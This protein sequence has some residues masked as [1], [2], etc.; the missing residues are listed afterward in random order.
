M[1]GLSGEAHGGALAGLVGLY[2]NV[3]VLSDAVV[4]FLEASDA[5]VD[6]VETFTGTRFGKPVGEGGLEELDEA[7]GD[8]WGYALK[9]IGFG[10][11]GSST[12]LMCSR[13]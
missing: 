12:L 10:C 11:E 4:V 3:I 5:L 8:T 7:L 1:S 13:M 2:G 6:L 9:R